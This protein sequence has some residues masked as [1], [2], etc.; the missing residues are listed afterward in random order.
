MIVGFLRGQA[1]PKPAGSEKFGSNHRERPREHRPRNGLVS[2][3]SIASIIRWVPGSTKAVSIIHHGVA[4]L[5]DAV[6]I[7]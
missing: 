6:L 4:I 3:Q 2:Y 7:S 1:S 5:G